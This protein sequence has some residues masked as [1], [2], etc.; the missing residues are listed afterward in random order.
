MYVPH[1][2]LAPTVL[3]LAFLAACADRTVFIG[4]DAVAPD[5]GPADAGT[6]DAAVTPR[7]IPDLSRWV[8]P[9]IGTQGSGNTFPGPCLPHGMVKPGP[10]THVETGNLVGYEYDDTRIE[11]FSHTQLDGPGGSSYGYSHV[12][13]LPATGEILTEETDYASAFSHDTEIAALGYYAVTLGD[14]GIRAELAASHHGGFHRYTFP[15]S[16]SAHVLIDLGHSRGASRDGHVE[17]SGST[18]KGFGVYSVQPLLTSLLEGWAPGT[19]GVATVY[20]AARFS[21]SPK[22]FGTWRADEQA[23]GAASADGKLIGAWLAFDTAEDEVIEARVGISFISVEEAERHIAGELEGRSFEDVRAAAVDA[24]NRLLS[25]VEVEGGTDDDRTRFY[26]ALYHALLQPADYTEHGRFWIGA[27][28]KGA[29]RDAG[30]HRYFTDNWC[31]WDTAKTT[32]P[33][34]T[35]VEPEV[36]GDMVQSMVWN[37]EEQG[38]MSKCTWNAT[39]DS[40]IMTANHAFCVVADAWVKGL[41][42]FDPATAYEAMRKGSLEDSP[43][44]M[45]DGLCGY[46]GQGT[47]PSY[48]ELGYVPKECDSMQAASMTLEYSYNDWCVST[49][50]AG[51]GRTEDAATFGARA[52]NWKNVWNPAQGF[53]QMKKEDGSWD[54]PFDP[55]KMDY[56]FTEANAWIYTWHVQHDVCGLVTAMGGHDAFTAKLNAFFDEGHFDMTNEPDFHA[57]WLY[58]RVGLPPKTSERVHALM[59]THFT[60]APGGLPGNDDAGA[61]SA[62][63][64]FAAMGL[65]PIAPGDGLYDLNVPL[66]DRVAIHL[67]PEIAGGRDFVLEAQGASEEKI[68]IA[69]AALNGKPLDRPQITHADITAGGRLVLELS[70]EPTNWGTDWKCGE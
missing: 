23:P 27:D 3:G 56:G 7:Q 55:A 42:D 6:P 20:F 50:A 59:R 52:S 29:V 16:G 12:L 21:K 37:Y 22:S 49:V 19:T 54:E 48:I 10:D 65:Y 39:G 33:L 47:P 57:P 17:I 2:R 11:G 26:T 32:H 28:G 46:L 18:V 62:W 25:R 51:L 30:A 60:T 61:T 34:V 43:N 14:Y 41:R 68:H 63:F 53:T 15:A 13:L 69:S 44:P 8:R 70:S 1:C 40:R 31:L 45:E 38:W 64:V 35:I 58:D 36:V 24:W 4:S 66:F 5:A 9:T 67:E